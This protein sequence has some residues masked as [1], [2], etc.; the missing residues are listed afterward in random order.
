VRDI[1]CTILEKSEDAEV[2]AER[3]QFLSQTMNSQVPKMH[4]VDD[5]HYAVSDGNY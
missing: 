3:H 5:S 1:T 2:S 4:N